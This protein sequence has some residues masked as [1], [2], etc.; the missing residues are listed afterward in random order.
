MC[1]YK[2][3]LIFSGSKNNKKESSTYQDQ[4]ISHSKDV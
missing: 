2:F 4:E 3:I 1:V